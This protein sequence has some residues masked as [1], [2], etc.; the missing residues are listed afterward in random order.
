VTD[1]EFARSVMTEAFPASTEPGMTLDL[2]RVVRDG[3]RAT[4]QRRAGLAVGGAALVG[5]IALVA[6]VGLPGGRPTTAVGPA[7]GSKSSATQASTGK[8]GAACATTPDLGALI[9]GGITTRV[10]ATPT[11]A[12][13]CTEHGDQQVITQ[14]FS[15]TDPTG[16]LDAEVDLGPSPAAVLSSAEAS[17]LALAG[18]S[19]P[20]VRPGS[21]CQP[22][23]PSGTVCVA[24][25]SKGGRSS[26][27]VTVSMPASPGV[28]VSL[29]ASGSSTGGPVPLEST[30]LSFL[31]E[32][33]AAHFLS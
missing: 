23:Q 19:A 10:N 8:S 1:E 31:A 17:K 22:T 33:I 25:V 20:G 2:D 6:W 15:L 26:I 18:M 12:S 5:V 14:S 11:S 27:V 28:Q 16:S 9:R 3:L 21:S 30:A 13:Q 24:Q 29:V 4:R 7:G 32:M